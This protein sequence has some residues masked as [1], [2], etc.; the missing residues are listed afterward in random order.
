MSR[1]LLSCICGAALVAA[2]RPAGA[3]LAVVDGTNLVQTTATAVATAQTVQNMIQQVNLMRQTLQTL[4]PTSF[5]G[6]QTLLGQGQLTYQMLSSDMT[7]L[8]FALRDVN[9]SFDRLFPEN[10]TTWHSARYADY[11]GYDGNWNAEITGSAKLAE[12]AQ[13]SVLLVESNNR[14]VASILTQSSAASGEI[15][16]LQLINQQLALI[17]ARL[18]DLVQNIAT[19]GRIT[20]SMAASSAGEK[21]LLRE[22]KLRRRDGYTSRGSPPRTLNRLP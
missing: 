11:D 7:T 5:S 16:Q 22:A 9:S 17:H 1:T 14:A 13:S 6:L 4:N 8:G 15:R 3:Q 20:A 2:G 12:R 18:G 21:L 10:K 19:M